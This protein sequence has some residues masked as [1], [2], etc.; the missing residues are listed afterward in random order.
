MRLVVSLR[1]VGT[2]NAAGVSATLASSTPGVTVVTTGPVSYPALATGASGA[3]PGG[4]LIMLATSLPCGQDLFFQMTTASAPGSD[5]STIPFT[6]GTGQPAVD[7]AS[8]TTPA[9][10]IPDNSTTGISVPLT[11][12]GLSG[13]IRD[14][15][16]SFDG[17]SCSP[18]AS[19]TTVGV[20]HWRSAICQ[21]S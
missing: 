2:G 6:I 20:T 12:S 9:V 15:E 16:F 13:A 18:S 11:V 21:R 1:N 19:W 10:A 4:Y 14:L 5:A 8:Y 7:I 17:T 3:N